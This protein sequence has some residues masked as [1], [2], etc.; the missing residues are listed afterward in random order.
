M[1][2]GSGTG[3]PGA[4]HGAPRG[5]PGAGP[6]QVGSRR[7]IDDEHVEW[8]RGPWTAW[9]GHWV[10]TAGSS[11]VVGRLELHLEEL[12]RG[13]VEL[14]PGPFTPWAGGL[15]A[16]GGRGG[17]RPGGRTT[18]RASL[19]HAARIPVTS[20][21]CCPTPEVRSRHEHGQ[22]ITPP[23]TPGSFRSRGTRVS[24]EH[25]RDILLRGPGL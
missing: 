12:R 10:P 8:R 22:A 6:G 20:S 4:R 1:D 5:V 2:L 25:T 15:G 3:K 23:A 19:R 13:P 18:L 24:G 14:D 11:T 16:P 9:K 21:G 7:C 17:G